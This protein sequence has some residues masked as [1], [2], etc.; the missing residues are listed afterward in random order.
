M[1]VDWRPD[2][3]PNE[4]SWLVVSVRLR[5]L[6]V[7][8]GGSARRQRPWRMRRRNPDRIGLRRHA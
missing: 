8:G 5:L 4:Q 6:L 1:P 7:A 2:S 3:F